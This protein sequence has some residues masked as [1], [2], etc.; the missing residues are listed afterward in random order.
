VAR[1]F[2]QAAARRLGLPGRTSLEIVSGEA[3]AREVTLRLA[4]IPPEDP[5]GPGRR[6]HSHRDCEECI[7]VLS[8]TGRTYAET[9]E[10][11]LQPGDTILLP[12]GERHMTRNTGN[13]PLRLLC[14]YPSA[15]VVTGTVEPDA[16]HAGHSD[17]AGAPDEAS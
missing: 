16:D 4:E 11:D 1:L 15:D 12:P 13:V 14:F 9:G 3:G 8:G 5:S 2:T 17:R 10:Y 7:F 6:P